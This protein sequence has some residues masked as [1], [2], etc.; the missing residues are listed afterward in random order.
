MLTLR[1]IAHRHFNEI[2]AERWDDCGE[3][4]RSRGAS[5]LRVRLAG[6]AGRA[7]TGA[8]GLDPD[9]LWKVWT[10]QVVSAG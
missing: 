4:R 3:G 9:G 8:T 7:S 1:E 2:G 5:G 6:L 10:F